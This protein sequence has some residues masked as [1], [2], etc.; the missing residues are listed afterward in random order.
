MLASGAGVSGQTAAPA[1]AGRIA[2]KMGSAGVLSAFARLSINGGLTAV[3]KTV[4]EEQVA[5]AE[6]VFAE[7]EDSP[8]RTVGERCAG[9]I[10]IAGGTQGAEWF[11]KEPALANA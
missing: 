7:V 10:R 3:R 2:V 6:N 4:G 1:G 5:G 9:V 8:G 11:L